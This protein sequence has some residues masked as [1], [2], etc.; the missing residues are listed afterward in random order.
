[1]TRQQT[2]QQRNK[3]TGKCLLCPKEAVRLYRID[4]DPVRLNFCLRHMLSARKS[5]AKRVGTKKPAVNCLSEFFK[6]L[7]AECAV[8]LLVNIS[9]KGSKP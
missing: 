4:G 2:Y 7:A 6:E 9:R 3:A 1:M 8:Q 5:Q